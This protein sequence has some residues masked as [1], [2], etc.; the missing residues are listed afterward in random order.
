MN[1]LFAQCSPIA[2]GNIGFNYFYAFFIFNLVS[3][4]CY[5]FFYPETK[6]CTLEQMDEIFGDATI[7]HALKDPELALAERQ[8]EKLDVK[9]QHIQH[10][11]VIGSV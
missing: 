4:F 9:G 6:G 7:A 2:L 8:D 11:E 1:L 3:A 5:L 10:N